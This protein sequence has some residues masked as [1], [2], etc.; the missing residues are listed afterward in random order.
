MQ[1]DDRGAISITT[2]EDR[3]SRLRLIPWWD[4]DIITNARAMVVGAGALGNEIIKNLALLGFGQVLIVDFDRI[5]HSNFSRGV[6]WKSDD[7][8]RRKSETAA[9]AMRS[10]NPECRVFSIDADVTRDV[11]LGV[12]RWADVVIC[13]L[14]NR[15][16]RLAVNSA[17]WRVNRPWIDGATESIMGV[18]RVFR[19]PDGPCYECTL[20]EQDQRVMA[21]RDSCGFLAREAYRQGHVPTTPTAASVIAG[22][23]VQEAVK[24]LHKNADLPNLAGK[25]F[26]F[27]GAT[28]DCFTIDYAR[29][30]DCL[31][32][33]T[34]A[35]II[36]TDLRSDT[37][38]LNDV[39]EEAARVLGPGATID[40]PDE[41]VTRLQC[42]ECCKSEEIYR[43]SRTIKAEQAAC[44]ACG[45]LRVPESVSE[46]AQGCD[47]GSMTL[48]ELGFAI[49]D[50]LPARLGEREAQIE[51]SGDSARVFG[52]EP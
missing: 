9:G 37:A 42:T 43:L 47:F 46:A 21:V 35:N 40:L 25:G 28:Y 15:E 22:I 17:C 12:F 36:A 45:K 13:G 14:D 44:P 1:R 20:S 51:I 2:E 19:P 5:E 6:L 4:Q 23:E 10:I 50:I 8:G 16:A 31:S 29:R 38:T 32:H 3:Y 52:G 39:L 26:F 11:G 34:Y 41:M 27:D 18:A 7:D 30:D 48:E 33:E 24:L 49:M